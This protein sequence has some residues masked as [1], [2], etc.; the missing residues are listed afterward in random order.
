MTKTAIAAVL[1]V[2][3]LPRSHGNAADEAG[4]FVT[5]GGAGELQCVEFISAMEQARRHP[6]RSVQY[7]KSIDAYVSYVSGFR[8]GFNH[9]WQGRQDI[10]EG[11]DV[12]EIMGKVE[13]ICR[14][15]PTAKFYQAL[16]ALVASRK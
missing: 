13:G 4:R 15:H 10:F 2:L 12:E 11:W 8:T 6:Y 14:E 3:L 5:G 9:G 16:I 7:W 1:V